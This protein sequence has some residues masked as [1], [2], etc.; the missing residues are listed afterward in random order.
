M[1]PEE[2]QER[3]KRL[4]EMRYRGFISYR[5]GKVYHWYSNAYGEIAMHQ[6]RG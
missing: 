2:K 1:T 4:Q 5:D 3:K 6:V